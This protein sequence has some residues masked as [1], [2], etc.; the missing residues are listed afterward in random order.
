MAEKTAGAKSVNKGLAGCMVWLLLGPEKVTKRE[1]VGEILAAHGI[2]DSQGN[3]ARCMFF[4]SDSKPDEIFAEMETYP[5]FG[6]KKAVII[7]ESEKL[8]RQDLERYLA[9]PLETTL[10][11]LMSEKPKGK[12]SAPLE[13]AVDKV[14]R[15]EVFWDLFED[16]LGPWA[17][18]KAAREYNLGIP[19]GFGEFLVD[20]CGRNMALIE[21]TIQILANRFSGKGFTLEDAMAVAGEQKGADVFDCIAACF[22]GNQV[23]VQKQV[24]EL[25]AEGESPVFIQIMLMRQAELLWNYV[26]GGKRTQAE[27]GVQPMAFREIQRQARGWTPRALARVIRRLAWLDQRLKSEPASVASLRLELVMLAIAGLLARK[28]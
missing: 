14:G 15:S 19:P 27:L 12:F 5:F 10:L 16:R 2:E 24:H 13:R 3:P 25:L 7:Q 8:P 23:V 28:R 22:T 17:E 4:A 21:Q 26:C 20:S 9:A 6:G 1:R 18:N 11:V